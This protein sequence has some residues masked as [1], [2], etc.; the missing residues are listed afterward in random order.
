MYNLWR[1]PRLIRLGISFHPVA[2]FAQSG[3]PA[4][5]IFNDAF[6]KVYA[7]GA[8]DAFTARFPHPIRLSSYVDDDTI[9]ATGTKAD[10][11]KL[12]PDA[13]EDFYH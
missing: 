8:F 2:L 10:L 9:M 7:I 5:D 3:L 6:V 11:L 13:A 12:V 1:S 4:G